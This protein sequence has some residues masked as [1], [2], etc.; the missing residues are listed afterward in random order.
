MLIGENRLIGFAPGHDQRKNI[1][2]ATPVF[3]LN[4]HFIGGFDLIALLQ[5]GKDDLFCLDNR[6]DHHL[7]APLG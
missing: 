5:F 3:F 2:I 6:H 4:H 1:F 7:T